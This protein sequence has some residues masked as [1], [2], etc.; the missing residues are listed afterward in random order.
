MSGTCSKHHRRTCS[1][2]RSVCT[3]RQQQL[4]TPQV[5]QAARNS[6]KWL[7]PPQV[8]SG[9]SNTHPSRTCSSQLGLNA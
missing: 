1:C 3:H 4:S 6:L 9:T 2:S 7:S 5:R 8:L